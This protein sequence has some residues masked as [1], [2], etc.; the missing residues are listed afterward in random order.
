MRDAL[1]NPIVQTPLL[2]PP[3]FPAPTG[4]SAAAI[5][6]REA[7]AGEGGPRE[8]KVDLNMGR[9]KF[10]SIIVDTVTGQVRREW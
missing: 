9:D 7:G 5:A 4:G 6:E 3:S 2:S 10:E 8:I 1:K